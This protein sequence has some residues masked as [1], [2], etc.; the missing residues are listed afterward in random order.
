MTFIQCTVSRAIKVAGVA[1]FAGLGIYT[2]KQFSTVF[3]E[4]SEPTTAFSGFGFTTLRLQSVKAVDHNTKR[5]VFEFPDPSARSG[6]PLTS[7]LLAITHPEGQWLPTVRPYTP[8]SDLDEPGH[9]ELMVK[10]YPSGKASG[11]LHSLQPGDTLKFATSLKGYQ[12][13]TNEYPH[14]YLLAGGAGITPIYQLI[15]GI[16]K[17]PQ[18]TTKISLVF[19]VNSEED[20]LLKDELDAF[21]KQF[22]DRFK[23]LYTV[24][25]PTREGGEYRKGYV[26]E[27][28]LRSAFRGER[29]E[30][31][32]VFVCGPP[33]MEDSLVGSNCSPGGGGGVLERLGFKKGQIHRF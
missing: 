5:L 9:V 1:G 33:A 22:P 13:K 18:D 12:W 19:G 29:S 23:Y 21:A 6:L 32:K 16:L 15:R 3:G 20:L 2:A 11:Y 24:S 14:V 28:L 7:A 4:S 31:V 17:N 30:N 26:D 10:K 25:R 27:E 8:I